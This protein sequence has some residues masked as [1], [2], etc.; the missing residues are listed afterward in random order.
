MKYVSLLG[1][2]AAPAAYLVVCAFAS[3]LLSY[4]L[5]FVLPRALDYQTL[6]FKCAEFMMMLSLFPLGRRLGLGKAD[7]GVALPRREFFRLLARGFALGALMLAIHVL[8]VLLLHARELDHDKLQ[9]ARAVSLSLKGVLIGLAV[10]SIEEPVFR[11]FL[12]GSLLRKT[13]R[14]NAVL[15]SAAY[16]ASLHFLNTDLRPEYDE[17]RWDTGFVLVLDAFRNLAA[18][19]LDSFLA[20]LAAGAFLACVRLLYPATGLAWCIGLHAGWVFVIKATKPMTQFNF[21]SPTYYLVSLF[22]GTIGYL[23]AGWTTVLIVLLAVKI[24][25]QSKVGFSVH[26]STGSG[27][28]ENP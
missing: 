21:Y 25:R 19:H 27:R 24:A 26:P 14:V 11:G 10:A 8:V 5:H 2:T 13:G 9:L 3:A 18:P 1:L 16:F 28:T 22:D 6:V 23:S 7:I 4:P 12:L 20:L 17:V 15:I